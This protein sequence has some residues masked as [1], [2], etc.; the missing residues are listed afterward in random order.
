MTS[1]ELGSKDLRNS[2]Q[3]QGFQPHTT[4]LVLLAFVGTCVAIALAWFAGQSTVSQIFAQIDCWQQSPPWWL[5]PPNL[6]GTYLLIPSIVFFLI[7]LVVMKASPRPRTWSRVIIVGILSALTIRYVLWRL[8]ATLHLSDPLNGVFSLGLVLMEAFVIFS[9]GFQLYLMLK[10]Q[11]RRQE[12]DRLAIAVLEHRYT[13]SV[14][15]FIPTYNEPSMI[16]RRTIIGCQAL[17]YDHKQVYLLDDLRRPE[18]CALARELGC[19]YITRS[20]NR[21]AKAGNLNHAIA[22]T[23]GELIVVFDADFVPTK[24]FLTRTIGFFQDPT[25]ALLQTQQS[26]YNADPVARNLGLEKVLTQEVE[27]FSRHYQ[28]LRD[29]VETALCYG[30]SFVARR[31]DLEQVGGFVTDSL[32]EDYFTSVRLSA[33]GQRVIYLN[34]VLSAGLSAENMAAH[35]SQR[36]RW[37]RGSLQAF[38]IQSNPLT[39][40]GLGL[41][42]RLAHLEGLLQWFTSL[43][44]VG[45]LLMPLAYSFGGVVPLRMTSGAWVYFFLPYYLVQLATFS[46]LNSRSRS[47]LISDIYAVAQCFPISLAVIQT[48]LDPFS[49]GFKVTQKGISSDRFIFNWVPASPLIVLF[50]AMAI[51]LWRNI[52]FAQMSQAEKMAA[53]PMD[54]E[55]LDSLSLAWVWSAYNLIMIGLALLILLDVP[56]PD[57]FEWFDLQRTVCLKVADQVFWGT[58]T[59]ISEA[60]VEVALTQSKQWVT[61]QPITL[62]IMEEGLSL[63]GQIIQIDSTAVI[64]TVR[65]K[66]DPLKL[67]Q[68]RQLVEMLFCRPGQWKSQST[69]GELRSLWLLVKSLLKPRV[70]FDRNA[71]IRPVGVTQG[72]R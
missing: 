39:I 44:R 36:L 56:K 31:Q 16:L 21:H 60:G 53:M 70:I 24:N 45:F 33:Q 10:V 41:V 23:K 9:N 61:N 14:D 69:P 48:L 50:V 27:I 58:T 29:G 17:E 64:P 7:A 37:A 43:C 2:K 35:I 46:W 68:Y 19:E 28:L 59:M 67:F 6:T 42:Q 40:P 20:D 11:S 30:S 49:K 54:A 3:R 57:L 26:F 34:E 18:I 5:D 63:K 22:K 55:L 12:A 1:S 38:F 65:V 72:F 15:I 66:F 71:N 52:Q 4:T 51:S 8:L 13:P 32:S 47:A 25:I 62:E